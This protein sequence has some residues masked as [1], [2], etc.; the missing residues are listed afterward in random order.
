MK[1]EETHS[2]LL[3]VVVVV[4]LVH[5]HKSADR[6]P[7]VLECD[8]RKLLRRVRFHFQRRP[9]VV[10]FLY[11]KW[12]QGLPVRLDCKPMAQSWQTLRLT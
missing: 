3:V 10:F 11:V 12:A 1:V 9:E 5:H 2:A 7:H 8:L 6:C 4:G